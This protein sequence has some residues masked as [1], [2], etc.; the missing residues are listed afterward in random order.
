MA[1]RVCYASKI[2]RSGSLRKFFFLRP[3]YSVT[4]VRKAVPYC[5]KFWQYLD[6]ILFLQI[7]HCLNKKLAVFSEHISIVKKEIIDYFISELME[8]LLRARSKMKTK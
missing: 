7:Q 4:P 2:R 6:A 5:T 8:T 1:A 3:V